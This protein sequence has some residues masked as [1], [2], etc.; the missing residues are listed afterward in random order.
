MSVSDVRPLVSIGIP[1]Y[2][3]AT[4]LGAA[5]DSARGQTFPNIEVIVV[6]DG[7]TD[8][9]P[10]VLAAYESDSRVRVVRH[11]VNRGATA[12]K[13]S[14]LDAM[15][16]A[17]CSILDSDDTL[18]PDAVERLVGEF[19][20]RGP[21]VG[22]V[23]GDCVDPDTGAI[24]GYGLEASGEVT[25]RD[26][27]TSRVTGEFWGMWRRDVLGTLR[28][29]EDLPG[30]SESLVWHELYRRTRV[31]YL[32]GVVR[33]YTRR[34]ADGETRSNLRPERLARTRAIYERY[35]EQFGSEIKRF[36]PGAYA[37]QLQLIAL[38]H[39][40]AGERLRGVARLVEAVRVAPTPGCILRAVALAVT[41]AIALRKMFDW[42]YE[43]SLRRTSK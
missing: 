30:G 27:V 8:G 2:N 7:S 39:L 12:A 14:V 41:P 4:C 40:L 42:R 35:L 38:W 25:F 28:F 20:R 18:L 29:D 17:Y 33:R 9:T 37:K 36:A 11:A 43:R 19:E 6:D 16:G 5:I 23:F 13:N 31:F 15:H 21:D 34:S 10:A 1:T 3:R 24:T 32:Q 22:M 26:V